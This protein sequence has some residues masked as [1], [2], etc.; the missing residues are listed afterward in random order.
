MTYTTASAF[1]QRFDAVEISQR[2]AREIPRL[3]TGRLLLDIAAG[4]DLTAYPPATVT[5]GTAALAVVQ[6]ALND[7]RDTIDSY[8]SGRYKLPIAPVPAVLERIACDL[9][10][11]Y[12]Y[13]DQVTEPVKQR[14]DASVKILSDVASGKAQL[15]ADAVS[16]EQPVSSAGAVVVSDGRQWDR[17][18]GRSF[19]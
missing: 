10:R 8:I 4:A 14:H 17:R 6:R 7:A 13:D 18:N 11:Y 2:V 16:G 19:L 3:V 15:G 12:L 1:L 9:G 5:A